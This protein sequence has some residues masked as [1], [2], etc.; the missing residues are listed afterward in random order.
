MHICRPR[1]TNSPICANP[2]DGRDDLCLKHVDEMRDG[3]RGLVIIIS[4]VGAGTTFMTLGFKM[5][6]IFMGRD[7]WLLALSPLAISSLR[8]FRSLSLFLS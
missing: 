8:S 6:N 4:C 7:L 3:V 2:C 5:I 1:Y